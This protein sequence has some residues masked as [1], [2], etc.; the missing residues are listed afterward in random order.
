MFLI[1]HRDI[2]GLQYLFEF[3]KQALGLP[4]QVLLPDVWI[5]LALSE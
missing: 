1:D 5:R 3:L 2:P 4:L